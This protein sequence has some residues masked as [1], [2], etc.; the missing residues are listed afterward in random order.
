MFKLRQV[1]FVILFLRQPVV[2]TEGEGCEAQKA[3]KTLE[4]TRRACVFVTLDE[5]ITPFLCQGVSPIPAPPGER[6]GE[7][8]RERGRE[9]EREGEINVLG[10]NLKGCIPLGNQAGTVDR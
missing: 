8:E 10:K 7:R 1:N 2:C 4:I 5:L 6:G 3:Y 9:G